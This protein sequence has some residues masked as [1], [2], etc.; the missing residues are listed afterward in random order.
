MTPFDDLFLLRAFVCIVE[1][2]NI[3][4]AARKL[5]VT[6]PTLSRYLQ[7]LEARCGHVLLYRDT[8]RMHLS[9]S[10]YQFLEEARSLLTMAEEAEQRRLN[11]QAILS[12]HIRLFSTIDF[13]QSIVSRLVTDFLQTHPAVTIELAYSNRPV[14]MI[15]EGCDVGIIAGAISDESIVAKF[16]GA[17]TRYPVVSPEFI[18]TKKT[19]LKPLE[20]QAWPWLTLTGIQ[21]GGEKEIVLYSSKGKRQKFTI[22]PTLTS[23]GVTSLREAALG[24]LGIAILPEWLIA[25]DVNQ[26]RLIRVLSKW[27]AEELPSY[28]VYPMQ[29]HLPLRVRSFIDYAISSMKTFLPL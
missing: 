9:S 10:G 19:P 21:F 15:Q 11:D 16:L 2:G 23:E 6:Q 17:I 1:S 4:A 22:A 18:A 7:T 14:H 29:R 26:K 8:H 5:K 24:G 28:I 13:G 3:S 27:Q 25:E 12:G 20:L